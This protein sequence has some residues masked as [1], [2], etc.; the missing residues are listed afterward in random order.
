MAEKALKLNNHNLKGSVIQ[1]FISKP[2][3]LQNAEDRTAFVNNLPAS[4]SEEDLR[5]HFGGS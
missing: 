4:C 2:P 5:T 1:I 3:A